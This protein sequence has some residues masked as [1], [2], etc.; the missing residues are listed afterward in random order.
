[1]FDFSYDLFFKVVGGSEDLG[2]C[3]EGFIVDVDFLFF[4]I[5]LL[6]LFVSYRVVFLRFRGVRVALFI[7]CGEE[8][9]RVIVGFCFV[10]IL[11][12]S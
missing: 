5:G 12:L 9:V 11:G 1:M 6:R 3:Y 4:Y 2:V 8:W 10:F 7:R